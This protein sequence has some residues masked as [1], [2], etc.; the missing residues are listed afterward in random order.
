MPY[1]T[2]ALQAK[3]AD[4]ATDLIS[5]IAIEHFRARVAHQL[6]GGSWNI[7][8]GE[9]DVRA[10]QS[11]D[12]SIIKFFCRYEADIRRTE[13]KIDDFAINHSNHC[14]VIAME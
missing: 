12:G 5:S 6:D 9:N 11:E 3:Q 1:C 4:K 13:A 10:I 14:K 2:I 8:G 7:D